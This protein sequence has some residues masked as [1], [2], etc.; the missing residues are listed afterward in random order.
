MQISQRFHNDTYAPGIATYGIQGKDGEQGTPGSSLFFSE[1]TL[2]GEFAEFAQKITSRLLPLKTKD[3]LLNRKFVNNDQFFDPEGKVFMLQD[4]NELIRVIK[5]GT[6][7]TNENINKIITQIGTFENKNITDEKGNVTKEVL[8]GNANGSLRSNKLTICDQND[9]TTG[10]GLL[11]IIQK[12][13]T[14]NKDVNYISMKSMYSGEH[15]MNLDIK[16]SKKYNGFMLSSNYPIY[17]DANV[18]TKYNNTNT[19][20]TNDYSPVYTVEQTN[21][22][23][24]TD[25][26]ST[27]KNVTCNIDASIYNYTHNDSS[28]IYY[29]VVYKIS[30][31]QNYKNQDSLNSFNKIL[32]DKANN[33]ILHFQNK[34]FQ[35]FRLCYDKIYDYNIVQNYDYVKLN[36]IINKVKYTDLP[37]VTVSLINGLESYVNIKDRTISGLKKNN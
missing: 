18:Y 15:D 7:V 19:V 4:I 22:K 3:I 16:F 27:C 36:D 23:N 6:S 26:I 24:I 8:F 2:P 9:N 21:N 35:D 14:G 20:K 32:E 12:D 34:E 17:L 11:S 25:F 1:Y 5:N 37:N 13:D 30:V 31:P 28:V 33:T 10:N 29:G